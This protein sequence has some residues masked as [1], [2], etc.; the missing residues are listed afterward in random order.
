MANIQNI[1]ATSSVQRSYMWEVEVQGLST[2]GLDSLAAY[3]KTVSIPQSAVEQTIINH[4]AG[5]SHFAGRNAAAHTTTITFW[6]DES[7][8]LT[9]YFQDWM[10]LIFDPDTGAGVQRDLYRAN[11]IIKLKDITDS[12]ENGVIELSNAWPMDMAEVALSYDSSEAIEVSVTFSYDKKL[13][14]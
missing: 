3:A 12:N 14:S 13:L 2:G 10:D 11:L 4:K 5:K 8:T 6:D 7:L 9:R 1:R